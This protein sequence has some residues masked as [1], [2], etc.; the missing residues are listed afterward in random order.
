[1]D[2]KTQKKLLEEGSRN[3]KTNNSSP[4]ST[5]SSSSFPPAQPAV[6]P[7]TNS[8]KEY[9]THSEDL[10]D[11]STNSYTSTQALRRQ[12]TTLSKF[13]EYDSEVVVEENEERKID[14]GEKEEEDVPVDVWGLAWIMLLVLGIGVLFPFNAFITA[15]D[16]FADL[17]PDFPFGFAVTLFY[18]WP[19]VISIFFSIKFAAKIP[20]SLRMT[21]FFSINAFIF[22]V[23]IFL[24]KIPGISTTVSLVITLICIALTGFSSGLLFASRSWSRRCL[25]SLLHH[26]SNVW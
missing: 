23:F 2:K 24:T 10:S 7:Q 16:Y 1:M 15:I 20:L 13:G 19:N 12:N 9:G 6:Q 26:C 11:H 22:I 8:E 14:V 25:S 18:Q 21:L 3:N 5:S 17:Y 4:S